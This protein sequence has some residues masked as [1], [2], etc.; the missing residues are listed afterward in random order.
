MCKKK[1]PPRIAEWILRRTTKSVE[2]FSILGDYEEEFIQ[3]TEEEGLKKAR[4][5]YWR[6][7]LNSVIPFFINKSYWR[8]AMMHNYMK[9]ALRNIKKQKGYSFINITGLAI[10][11]ACCILLVLYIHSELS[12]DNYHENI[13]R[14]FRLCVH[15]NIGGTD[16][17]GSA[18]N[19][20]AAAF[21]RDEY[22]EVENAV[23]FFGRSGA[24]VTYE[25]KH[26]YIRR[27][28]YV[29]ESVFDVFTWPIIKGDQR[30]ALSAPYS[31]VIAEDVAQACF[32]DTDPLGKILRFNDREDFIVTGV[33]KNIPQHSHLVWDALCSFKTLHS[34]MG[35]NSPI[36]NHWLSFNFR[37]YLLLQ[38]GVDY[39]DV[40]NK[41]HGLLEEVAGDEMKAKGATEELFLQPVKDIYLRPLGQSVGPIQYVYIFSVV[42]MFVLV[43]ACVN[44]MNLSTAR[45]ANRAR[46][47]GIRKVLGAHRMR[48][49][50]QFLSETLLLSLFS[51]VIALL[52]VQLALP[53]IN[54]FLRWELS[55]TSVE[56]GWLV[57]S[58]IWF[59]IFVGIVA[60]SYPAFFLSG[61]QP[62]KVL[63]G[64][65][66]SG[67]SNSRLR[68]IL[69]VLQ[70]T[71]SITLIIGIG[72]IIG[73]LNF[74]KN[75]DPGFKKEHVVVIPARDR[76]VQRSIQVIK[77]EFNGHPGVVSVAAS[78]TIPGWG[79]AS[80]DKIPEGYT[81]EEV[82]LMDEIN[83]DEDF[84]PTLGMELVAGRNFSK[85]R[86]EKHSV[87]INETAVRRYGW[88]DPVG[89]TIRAVD[90]YDIG[91][92]TPKTVIGVVKDFHL[93]PLSETIHPL[94]MGNDPDYPFSFNFMDLVLVRVGYDDIT[95][96]LNFIENKWKELFPEQQFN[97]F[98]LDEN[99]N[100]Q[101]RDIERSREIFS[102]FTF[103][104]ILIA[105]LGL[106]GM[107]SFTAEQRNKE[108][109]IRKVLGSSVPGIVMLLGKELI[110]LVIV[111][112]AFAWPVAYLMLNRWLQGFPYRISMTIVPFVVSAI[113]V[114]LI[115]FL[116]I[117]YQAIRAAMA[118]P[119][120]SLRYE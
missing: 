84:I 23:R 16:H 11:M 49:V 77:D 67:S 35:E 116:T 21:L 100:L 87:I 13:D 47:V 43:I 120:E 99:F 37:T 57:P 88:M 86:D 31:V 27:V 65:M 19:G 107:A 72:L 17:I 52:L 93:R 1:Y 7:T 10:G 45:S 30:S 59:V 5:W 38:E 114:V 32:G 55:F 60:G 58:L 63:G 48:L 36:L 119:V 41:V 50:F 90:P 44:F 79:S 33:M 39:R 54:T 66:I 56:V 76:S 80:N 73:Q 40:D 68:R 14:I 102:Y 109:G 106:F 61:F 103:L 75:K 8:F 110:V 46:E 51:L 94:F 97:Y 6:Q 12:V 2:K 91:S 9:I 98:F 22:P 18:S 74:M 81:Q 78:S 118:N 95:G 83:V 69:V 96:T 62:V 70:F 24:R 15:V 20:P 108:I 53:Q 29:D 71:I 85:A 42:A 112:N 25:D 4:I 26:F 113:L 89:K 34:I 82:Q 115:S 64:R 92:W 111:A 101:F 117:A 105:C 28:A 104:A 3:I